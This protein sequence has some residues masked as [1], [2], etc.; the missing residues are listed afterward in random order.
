[1]FL[2]ACD[3]AI[4]SLVRGMVGV[5]M[6]SR[7]Y[8]ILAAGKPILAL[9]EVGSELAQVVEEEQVGWVVP[10]ADP[11]SLTE[12]VIEILNQRTRLQAMGKSARKA[13]L[14]KYSLAS[15]IEKYRRMI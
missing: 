3:V 15:A 11:T 7:T 14:A 4:V 5:S 8:N 1:M 10:P 9:T 6:P 2:N 13:A 12:T